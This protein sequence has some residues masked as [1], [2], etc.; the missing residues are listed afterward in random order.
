[1]KDK[2]RKAQHEREQLECQLQTEKDEKELYKVKSFSSVGLCL[3]PVGFWGW[4]LESSSAGCLVTC[5]VIV[6]R[7]TRTVVS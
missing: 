5:L 3:A 4:G 1:M 2:L 6:T 7:M